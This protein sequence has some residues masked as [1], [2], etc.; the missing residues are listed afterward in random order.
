MEL[1]CQTPLLPEHF[2]AS[3]Y[4]FSIHTNSKL[5]STFH[6]VIQRVRESG[7]LSENNIKKKKKMNSVKNIFA[8]RLVEGVFPQRIGFFGS[9]AYGHVLAEVLIF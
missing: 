7:F 4:N 9:Y 2:N 3:S 5:T 6:F 8:Y 1:P